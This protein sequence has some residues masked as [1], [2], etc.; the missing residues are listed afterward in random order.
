MLTDF[1]QQLFLLKILTL[2]DFVFRKL[3]LCSKTIVRKLTLT[4]KNFDCR[5]LTLNPALPEQFAIFKT[6]LIVD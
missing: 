5:N 6:F 4:L 2:D 3:F 1:I